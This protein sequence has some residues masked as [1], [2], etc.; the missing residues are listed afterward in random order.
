M[1]RIIGNIIDYIILFGIMFI[2]GGFVMSMFADAG[3]P[4]PFVL[5][6]M[7][8]FPVKFTYNIYL[9]PQA[10]NNLTLIL[11]IMAFLF[12]METL[13]FSI[14]EFFM[15][16]ATIGRKRANTLLV[17]D[18]NERL[19]F[20]T[21]F[22]RNLLKTISRYFYCIPVLPMFFLK[23]HKTLYDIILKTKVIRQGV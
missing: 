15:N 6:M 22:V 11:G 12:V 1:D 20:N 13:Y 7:I 14:M 2:S 23:G 19:T 18:D 5:I 3:S 10:Y 8:F 17:K 16:G 9:Y 4:Y 21:I